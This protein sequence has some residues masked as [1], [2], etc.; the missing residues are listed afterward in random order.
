MFL[1]LCNFRQEKGKRF[2]EEELFYHNDIVFQISLL[3][4]RKGK[5][6]R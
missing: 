3:L 1:I 6:V 4:H 5:F 2:L